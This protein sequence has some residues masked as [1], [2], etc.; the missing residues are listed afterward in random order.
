LRADSVE[1]GI[2]DVFSIAV[3]QN[4]FEVG[5]RGKQ[6]M[7]EDWDIS[8]KLRELGYDIHIDSS[9]PILHAGTHNFTRGPSL[10]TDVKRKGLSYD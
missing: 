10:N 5:I 8:Y 1:E 6:Y 9:F 4:V 7:S 3:V 2:R